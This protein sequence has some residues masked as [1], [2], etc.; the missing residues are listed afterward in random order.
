MISNIQEYIQLLKEKELGSDLE[1]ER[2]LTEIAPKKLSIQFQGFGPEYDVLDLRTICTKEE[3]MIGTNPPGDN[4]NHHSENKDT[5]DKKKHGDDKIPVDCD[6][7][8]NLKTGRNVFN[9]K[10]EF[11]NV[12]NAGDKSKSPFSN[13][14]RFNEKLFNEYTN[15]YSEDYDAEYE[16][17]I[18]KVRRTTGLF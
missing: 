12:E 6:T 16:S 5:N 11:I 13:A 10:R 18:N 2:R 15:F 3:L 4:A 9:P 17:F 7:S 14:K 1:A 8:S